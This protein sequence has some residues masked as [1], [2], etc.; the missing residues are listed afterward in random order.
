MRILKNEVIRLI[1][2]SLQKTF[3]VRIKKYISE[4]DLTTQKDVPH[5]YYHAD[6]TYSPWVTHKSFQ[7][8][9]EIAKKYTLIDQYRL[10]DLYQL[11]S[12]AT[13][14]SG[15]FLEVGAWRGGSSAIINTAIVSSD[16]AKRFFVADTFSGVVKAGSSEDTAY[17]GGEHA[18]ASIADVK[19]CFKKL[20][21]ISPEILIGVFPDD[22]PNLEIEELAFVHCDVDA[23][24]STKGVIE[25]CLP[26]MSTGGIIIFDDYGSKDCVGV[27][28]YVNSL[29]EDKKFME[30]YLFIHNLNGHAIFIKR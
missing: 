11:A 15:D 8:A 20:N 24:E 18:D 27:T 2:F 25:W 9:Y 28:R 29:V 12:Q 26:R 5:T 4:N 30:D 10:F 23:H 21:Q 6:A 17:Q 13:K 16:R 3:G 19:N 1:N 14:I 22:H 7:D